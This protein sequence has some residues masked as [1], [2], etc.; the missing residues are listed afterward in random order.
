[1]RY[2]PILAILVFTLVTPAKAE[3]SFQTSSLDI[4]TSQGEQHFTI[5]LALT[6]EDQVRGLMFRKS[7][8]KD[9][10]ML[11]VFDT[12]R[13]VSFWMKNTY[14]PLDMIFIRED[15]TIESILA[16]TKPETTYSLRSQG[17]VKAVLEINAG[18][19]KTLHIAAGDRVVHEFFT[20]K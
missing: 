7:M 2:I 16:N 1:M 10:G 15:G 17:K 8:P 6:R 11:F 3:H 19:S 13:E 20:K 14:I 5:E 18:L 9:H 4:K 12:P